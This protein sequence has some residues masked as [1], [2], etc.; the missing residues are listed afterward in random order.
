MDELPHIYRYSMLLHL[1]A[2]FEYLF[3]NI[4]LED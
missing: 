4:L 3:N 2:G 1:L